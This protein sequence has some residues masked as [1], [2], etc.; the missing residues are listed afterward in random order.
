MALK[1]VGYKIHRFSET[2]HL[3]NGLSFGPICSSLQTAEVSYAQ[4]GKGNPPLNIANLKKKS[5]PL[6]EQTYEP[7]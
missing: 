1:E 7:P 3:V 5:F 6:T 4:P 2:C